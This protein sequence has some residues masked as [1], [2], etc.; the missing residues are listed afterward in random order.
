L[1]GLEAVRSGHLAAARVHGDALLQDARAQARQ[2]AARSASDA[3][4]LIEQAEKEGEEAAE[5]DTSREWTAARR[6]ARGTVLAAQQEV[7]EQLHAAVAAAVRADPRY[8]ALLER[9]A[10]EARRTL[11]PG[12]DVRV[13]ERGDLGV[14][15]T[16]KDRHVDW[17]LDSIVSEC[18]DKL[19]PGV[20]GLW[21]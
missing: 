4:A 17:S 5:L 13:D 2:I 7:L 12:A 21:R 10:D 6:R 15:A 3:A 14:S 1:N 8:P 9:L 20:V 18:I 19:G 16:R 11:G